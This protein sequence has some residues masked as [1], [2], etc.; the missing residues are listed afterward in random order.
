MIGLRASRW[1]S[2]R[3]NQ[4]IGEEKPRW[5]LEDAILPSHI[6]DS[7]WCRG[8]EQARI[9]FEGVLYEKA[10]RGLIW[11]QWGNGK[12]GGEQMGILS[13]NTLQRYQSI[14]RDWQ[15]GIAR[16]YLIS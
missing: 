10:R 11:G 3:G 5:G 2:H 7:W 8:S 1:E 4:T 9:D 16:D 6:F 15:D 14:M 12:G 13:F